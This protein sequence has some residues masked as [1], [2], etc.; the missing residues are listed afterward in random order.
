MKLFGWL[1]KL[2]DR[3]VIV[4]HLLKNTSK[5]FQQIYISQCNKK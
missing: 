4:W 2:D 5:S 1:V 3:N